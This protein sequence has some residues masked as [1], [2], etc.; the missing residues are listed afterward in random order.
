MFLCF[1]H[2]SLC[3]FL[4]QV[5]AGFSPC[6]TIFLADTTSSFASARKTHH[7]VIF[8]YGCCYVGLPK[9]EICLCKKRLL[10]NLP[11]PKPLANL[12]LYVQINFCCAFFLWVDGSRFVGFMEKMMSIEPKRGQLY[13]VFF[14]LPKNLGESNIH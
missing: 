6:F 5:L 11:T 9:H 7:L 3:K 4:A 13:N 8:I 10:P 14:C 12:H 2:G 1:K